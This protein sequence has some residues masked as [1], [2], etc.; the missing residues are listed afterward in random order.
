MGEF[1]NYVGEL[2]QINPNYVSSSDVPT[3]EIRGSEFFGFD[4]KIYSLLSTPNLKKTYTDL[5][6]RVD[7]YNKILSSRASGVK[8]G[9]ASLNIAK[10]KINELKTQKKAIEDKMKSMTHTFSK[11]KYEKELFDINTVLKKAIESAQKIQN[12]INQDQSQIPIIQNMIDSWTK[13]ISDIEKGVKIPVE[14]KIDTDTKEKVDVDF[15]DSSSPSVGN[16][17][18]LVESGNKFKI[19]STHLLLAAIIVGGVVLIVKKKK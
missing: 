13:Q 1:Y 12:K 19:S 8:S 7:E 15:Q 10:S 6:N 17:L 14:T 18:E 4:E 9:I 2:G 3:S 11:A 5:N 16:E